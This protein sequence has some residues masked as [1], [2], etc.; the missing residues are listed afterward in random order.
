MKISGT[1]MIL[2]SALLLGLFF[3]PLWNIRLEAPQYPDPL[4]MDIYI[5]GIEGEEE[6]DIQNIDGVNHYIGMKKIPKPEEMWEFNVFPIVIGSMAGLGI[7]LG[8]LG[9]FGKISPHWFMGWLVLMIILGIL[10]MYDFNNWLL[11]YGTDLD[12]KAIIKLTDAE[13]NP[14][15]YKPPLLGSEKILNFTAHSYPRTGAY[16]MFI[17]MFLT[18]IAWFA[19]FRTVKTKK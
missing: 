6:F 3:Y 15:N 12:P 14:L 7:L 16:M 9:F 17:G 2:G 5:A 1:I 8:F 19:G 13:G 11:D 18:L 4:G 10:G